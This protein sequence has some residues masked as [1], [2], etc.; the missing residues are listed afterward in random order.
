MED[1]GSDVRSKRLAKLQ[2]QQQSQL[3]QETTAPTPR[4]IPLSSKEPEVR[5]PVAATTST[6]VTATTPTKKATDKVASPVKARICLCVCLSIVLLCLFVCVFVHLSTI[7][8][9]Q[10]QTI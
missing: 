10:L 7:I 9:T 3:V 2:Q 4:S 6:P 5:R 8:I 1:A